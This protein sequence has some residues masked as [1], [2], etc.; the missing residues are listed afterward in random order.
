MMFFDDYEPLFNHGSSM[1]LPSPVVNLVLVLALG[2][3][4]FNAG[5]SN[6]SY[7]TTIR[8]KIISVLRNWSG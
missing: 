2:C 6:S 5:I 3:P 7:Q 1:G 4:Y 8:V